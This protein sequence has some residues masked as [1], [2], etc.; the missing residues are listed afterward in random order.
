M[1]KE[2]NINRTEEKVSEETQEPREKAVRIG[3]LW[4][5]TSE[6]GKHYK[7]GVVDFGPLGELHV[8]LFPEEKKNDNENEDE[9]ENKKPDYVLVCEKN[10]IGAFWLRISKAGKKFLSGSILGVPV[11]IF[12]NERKHNDKAPDYRI[13]KFDPEPEDE[14]SEESF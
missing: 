12:R 1:E 4:N 10:R 3:A 5:R 7:S 8:A 2:K 11:N 14:P 9:N 6:T 13:V